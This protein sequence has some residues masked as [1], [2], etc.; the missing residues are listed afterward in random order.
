MVI[1]QMIRAP[2]VAQ[3]RQANKIHSKHSHM[4][5][6]KGGAQKT[7]DLLSL[8]L[9]LSSLLKSARERCRIIEICCCIH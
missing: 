6:K 2:S 5:Q 9:S 3:K 8:S 4:R 1:K 7:S